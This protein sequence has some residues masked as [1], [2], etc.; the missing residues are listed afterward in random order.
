ML[1]P[2]A[3]YKMSK[4]TKASLALGKFKNVHDRNAW[5]RSMIQAE[6]AAAI[7][8]KREKNVRRDTPTE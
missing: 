4:T 5:K 1:K 2:T 3:S 8:P 7:Q 6:L